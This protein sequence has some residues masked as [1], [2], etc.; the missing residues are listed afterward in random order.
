VGGELKVD[1]GRLV[2][3][4]MTKIQA[5]VNRRSKAALAH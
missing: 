4:D 1:R 3:Q 2:N 5:E